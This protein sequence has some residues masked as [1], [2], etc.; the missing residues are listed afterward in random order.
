MSLFPTPNDTIAINYRYTALPAILT[1]VNK[2]PAGVTSHAE[3]IAAS[4]LAKAEVEFQRTLGPMNQY[5]MQRLQAS[6]MLDSGFAAD[7]Q[8]D[9]LFDMSGREAA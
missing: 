8:D 7:S 5:Y 4:C 3:T 6:V 2:Y 9:D 1:A